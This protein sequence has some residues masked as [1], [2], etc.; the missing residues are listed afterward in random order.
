M[1]R[2]LDRGLRRAARAAADLRAGRDRPRARDARAD[3]AADRARPRLRRRGRV[4]RRLLRRAVLAG[5]RR[6]DPAEG[7][8]HGGRRGRRPA[9]Q[10][11]PARLR[12]LEGPQG[13]RAG[14]RLVAL[15]RGGAAARAGT[16]S[17]RRWPA[18]TSARP[19]TSTAAA[20]T[21]ASPTTRTSRPSR[22]RPGTPFASYWMHNAWITTSGEK[23][24]KS[25]GNSLLVPAV[26]ERVRGIELR[27]YM[28]AAHYRSTVEFSFEALEEA[29]AGFRRI[30]GFLD[31][32]RVG[33]RAAARAGHV[34]CRLR[35]GD[36]RRPR[37]P[38]RRR[39]RLRRRARG[40][41]AARRRRRRAPC[42]AAS[43]RC[44]P[45]SACSGSTRPTP[46]GRPVRADDLHRR[47]RRAGARACWS[48]APQARAD[49]DFATADAIRDRI[50][51]A[52][53]EIE[54][55]P[56]GPKWSVES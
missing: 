14:D 13:L 8:R 1:K 44:G 32:V 11:R 42:A 51:A 40:Q 22:A 53:V 41:Q 35:R 43:P 17:A 46:T 25:L 5:V 34:P 16:S 36:G 26:L 19:S 12:P 9:R 47:R 30:E 56:T 4:G 6:A 7:R 52:G 23:M 3:R 38:R 31:R 27:Y 54:D 39:G 28:V 15:A 10:A 55:T 2:E 37:H 45:C 29:A 20:S 50:K 49:K 48:S 33:A 24:S 18:S 21:C